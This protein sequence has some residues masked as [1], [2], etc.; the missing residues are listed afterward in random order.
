MVLL[1]LAVIWAAVLIPPFLRARAEGRPADSIGDFRRR[2]VVLERSGP[3]LMAPANRLRSNGGSYPVAQQVFTPQYTGMAQ[4]PRGNADYRRARTLR[5]RRDVLMGMLVSMGGTLLLGVLPPLRILWMA[6]VALDV[7]FIGYCA[8][9]IR[10][11]NIAAE[12]AMKLRVLPGGAARYDYNT[13]P[14]P[15]LVLQRSAR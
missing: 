12:K 7:L 6:H 3:S 5:R 9:L 15:A 8:M 2:L 1:I 4:A 11:R 13:A 10:A 14:E